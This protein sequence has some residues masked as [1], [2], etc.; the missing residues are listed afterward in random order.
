MAYFLSSGID[1]RSGWGFNAP[2][3]PRK[4]ADFGRG[5]ASFGGDPG[6]AVIARAVIPMLWPDVFTLA[7]YGDN[8][9]IV[10]A[11]DRNDLL[12]V[13]A[14]PRGESAGTF[15]DDGTWTSSEADGSWTLTLSNSIERTVELEATVRTLAQPFEVCGVPLGG[16]PLADEDWSCDAETGVLTVTYTSTSA[17]LE[18]SG[19]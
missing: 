8:P 9:E 12:H 4:R 17:P 16:V 5:L 14:F 19:C 7:E 3:L 1:E 2:W 10:H 13:L 6:I 18:V 11:S 15:Y